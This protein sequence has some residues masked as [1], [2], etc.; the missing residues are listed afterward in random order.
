MRLGLTGFEGVILSVTTLKTPG[1]VCKVALA[2][3]T[4]PFIIRF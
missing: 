2:K 3:R 1:N 4:T